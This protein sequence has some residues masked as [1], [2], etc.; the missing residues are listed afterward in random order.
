MSNGTLMTPE[1]LGQGT[2]THDQFSSVINDLP[3]SY[4]YNVHR[5]SVSVAVDMTGIANPRPGRR[6]T[7]VNTGAWPI[8]L[9]DND[10]RSLSQNRLT[11]PS[12]ADIEV[13]VGEAIDAVYD[14]DQSGGRWR[15]GDLEPASGGG[16]GVTPAVFYAIGSSTA[17]LGTS[18]STLAL[19]SATISDTGYSQLGGIITIG[20]EL[21]GKTARVDWA[22]GGSGATNRVE[23]R[24][25]LQVDTGGGYSAVKTSSNYTA[26]NGTQNT[27][28]V[29]GHHYL[30]LS[31]GMTIRVQALRD[32]STCNLIT[33]AC[34]V[35]IQTL[36]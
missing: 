16:S 17:N 31:T 29:Q 18:L 5:L 34:S 12:N 28:G 2:Q 25:E 35:G 14:E 36:S 32:G 24:S 9:R 26:R 7:L 10:G 20:S 15:V 4:N 6:V 8:T 21:N 1:Q 33:D 22:V 30:T 3:A 27:G 11:T 13:R 19:A 23:V